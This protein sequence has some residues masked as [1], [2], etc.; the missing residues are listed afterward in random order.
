MNAQEDTNLS[1]PPYVRVK[2]A[3]EKIKNVLRWFVWHG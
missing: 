1:T 3:S 2:S